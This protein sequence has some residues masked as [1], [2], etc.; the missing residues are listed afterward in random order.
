[1]AAA[2]AVVKMIF[3]FLF[4]PQSRFLF[5]KTSYHTFYVIF[6]GGNTRLLE[7][8]IQIV[9]FNHKYEKTAFSLLY[10]LWLSLAL[11]PIPLSHYQ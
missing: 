7:Y 10:I 1:M 4:P 3:S 5:A 9:L 8:K 2:A 6:M 11:L